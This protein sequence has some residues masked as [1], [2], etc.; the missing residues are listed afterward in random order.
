MFKYT[1]YFFH[2]L[3]FYCKDNPKLKEELYENLDV[4]MYFINFSESCLNC[5][6]E[7]FYMHS[8]LLYN[9]IRDCKNK[10]AFQKALNIIQKTYFYNKTFSKD[11]NIFDL[12]FEYIKISNTEKSAYHVEKKE[13][14]QYVKIKHKYYRQS[15]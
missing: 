5:L 9:L 10:F 6:I 3:T 11:F 14:Y 4:F 2:F 8:S 7:I 13:T 15:Q 1:C 12:I